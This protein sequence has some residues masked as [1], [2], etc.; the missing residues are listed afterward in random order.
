MSNNLKGEKI[1]LNDLILEFLEMSDVYSLLGKAKERMGVDLAFRFSDSGRTITCS[2]CREFSGNAKSFPMAEIKR[3]YET[4]SVVNGTSLYGFVFFSVKSVE[5]GNPVLEALIIGLRFLFQREMHSERNKRLFISGFFEDLIFNRISSELELRKRGEILGIP[6]NEES[7][8]FVTSGLPEEKHDILISRIKAFFQRNYTVSIK[9]MLINILFLRN[10]KFDA[11]KE[12]LSQIVD[13]VQQEISQSDKKEPISFYYG[14]GELC[15]SL[16]L[17]SESYT[18]AKNTMIFNIL[19]EKKIFFW[20]DIGAFRLICSLAAS[21]DADSFCSAILGPLIEYDRKHN[22]NLLD[23]LSAIESCNWNLALAAEKLFFHY[24][25]LKYRYG[26]LQ[27]VLKSDLKDS[28]LRF[29]LAFSLRVEAIR[30][31]Q[32]RFE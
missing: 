14:A 15:P 30:K 28:S 6:M 29:D 22:T 12:N 20:R 4:H 2:E 11:L 18:E 31:M 16:L 1:P 13:S 32:K 24:N 7:L 5:K 21:K 26:K 27:K 19:H 17:L 9:G 3:I 8:I 10:M 25:T 23:T